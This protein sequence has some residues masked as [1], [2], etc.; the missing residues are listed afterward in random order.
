MTRALEA[1]RP[2][3]DSL[4]C[5]DPAALWD[6]FAASLRGQPFAQCAL[7]QAAYDL[8]GKLRGAPVYRLWGL[9]TEH[10][11]ITNYTIGIDAIDVM[12]AKMREFPDWPV[13][14]IKLGTPHDLQIVA[15][16]RRHT[17]SRFRVDANCGWTVD[18]TIDNSRALRD[19]YVEFI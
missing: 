2:R 8:W 7:D 13:Y 12:V 11:P 15:E 17:R 16:L 4:P 1:L 5:D 9:T 14:K 10:T 3:L 18:E 6:R 19:L